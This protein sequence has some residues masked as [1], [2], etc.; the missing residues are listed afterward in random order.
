MNTVAAD[1]LPA[2]VANE[3]IRLPTSWI[4]GRVVEPPTDDE[5]DRACSP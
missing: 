5:L 3:I 4:P 2:S 1:A